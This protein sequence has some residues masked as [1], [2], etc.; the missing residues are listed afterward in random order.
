MTFTI[1][2]DT[3]EFVA[4]FVWYFLYLSYIFP[5]KL[6]SHYFKLLVIPITVSLLTRNIINC[7]W[8]KR[9]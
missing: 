9:A 3:R 8:F 2:I 7:G 4:E 6:L 5:K 1:F